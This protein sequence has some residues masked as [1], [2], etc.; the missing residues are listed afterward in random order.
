MTGLEEGTAYQARVRARYHDDDGNLEKSGPWSAVEETAV[1]QTPPPTKPTGL[2]TAASHDSVLLSWDNPDDD[3]ITG[4][5]VLRGP[6]A[7]NLAVLV[8]DTGTR[9]HQLH[10]RHR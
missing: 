9:E 7:D 6:D 1:A 10:R 3:T 8:D 4:Y 2:I 5:Q